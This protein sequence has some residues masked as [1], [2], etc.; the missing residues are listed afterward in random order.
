MSIR[1]PK[2]LVIHCTPTNEVFYEF[3]LLNIRAIHNK[4]VS[5]G[6]MTLVIKEGVAAKMFSSLA[7]SMDGLNTQDLL[8]QIMI[9]KA[10]P[11]SLDL[12]EKKIK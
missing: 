1:E 11:S 4:F 6:K 10:V 2:Y 3:N 8:V 9:N 12:L 7:V 5:E